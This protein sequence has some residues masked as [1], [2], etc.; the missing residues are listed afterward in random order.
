MA[1]NLWKFDIGNKFDLSCYHVFSKSHKYE[2]L[3][4]RTPRVVTTVQEILNRNSQSITFIQTADEKQ[5]T[6]KITIEPF[7]RSYANRTDVK[8]SRIDVSIMF[9]LLLLLQLFAG[10]FL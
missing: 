4:E 3:I 6:Y 8:L 9:F 5:K 2:K 1:F 7:N 10:I